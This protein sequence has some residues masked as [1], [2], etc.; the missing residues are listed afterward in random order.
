MLVEE[1]N[2][3]VGGNARVGRTLLSDALEFALCFAFD[4]AF[5][6]ILLLPVTLQCPNK[7]SKENTNTT[8]CS[9]TTRKQDE[10][11]SLHSAKPIASLSLQKPE[12]P[13]STAACMTI[14][15]ATTFMPPW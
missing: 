11:Y 14:P 6:L 12:T 10:P 2:A 3:P 4:F 9:P 8:A 5:A 15:N 1:G 7:L 13:S